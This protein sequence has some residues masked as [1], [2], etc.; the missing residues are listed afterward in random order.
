VGWAVTM[1]VLWLA[2]HTEKARAVTSAA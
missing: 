2:G 1:R